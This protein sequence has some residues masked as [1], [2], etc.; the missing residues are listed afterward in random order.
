M[1]ATPV[2]HARILVADDDRDVRELLIS[3]LE[4]LGYRVLAASNGPL[5][6]EMIEKNS[7]IQLPTS[8]RNARDEWN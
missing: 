8:Y 2:G 4:S 1:T 3:C 6:I 5:A 7:D